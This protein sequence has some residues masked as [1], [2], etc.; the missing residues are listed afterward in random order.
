M[1]LVHSTTKG[2]AGLAMALAHSRGLFDY[3]ERVSRYWPEFAQQ[4]NH[5]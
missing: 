5:R 2:L 3:E 1:A 4:G